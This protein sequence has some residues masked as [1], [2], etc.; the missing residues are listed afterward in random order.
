MSYKHVLV[1]IDLTEASDIVISKAV[2]LAKNLDAKLSFISIDISHPDPD[3]IYDPLE[4][5]LIEQNREKLTAKLK[6]LA[7]LTNYPITTTK[8]VGGDV[9]ETLMREITKIKADLLVC[10]H[11]H[12]FWNRWWSS[13]RKLVNITIVDL[14]LIHL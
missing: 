12:G 14:L 6:E 2:S 8:V 9:E 11:H 13:A 3:R 1:A 7:E 5:K 10:G 4:V